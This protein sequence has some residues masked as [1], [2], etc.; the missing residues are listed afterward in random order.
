MKKSRLLGLGLLGFLEK[1]RLR[2]GISPGHWLLRWS[3]NVSLPESD[4]MQDADSI[5]IQQEPLRARILLHALFGVFILFVG[6]W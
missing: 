3:D 1:L 4:F 6:N 2:F 5:I